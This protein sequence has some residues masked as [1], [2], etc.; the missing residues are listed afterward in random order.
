MREGGTMKL[1][2]LFVFGSG[3]AIGYL[4]GSAAG[5]QRFD[6]IIGAAAGLAADM[7]YPEVAAQITRRSGDVLTPHLTEAPARAA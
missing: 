2:R 7:G 5:R 4:A 6:Q 1:R 3:L